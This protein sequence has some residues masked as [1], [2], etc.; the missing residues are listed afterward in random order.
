[1][2]IPKDITK[3]NVLE[4]LKLIDKNGVPR[5]RVYERYFLDFNESKYPVKYVISLANIFAFE[6]QTELPPSNFTTLQAQDFLKKMNFDIVDTLEEEGD[7]HSGF[8]LLRLKLINNKLLGDIDFSF[9]NSKDKQNTIYT[10]VVIGPNGT[11][12]S[13][14]FRIIIE[15]FKELN[16]LKNGQPRKSNVSG[17]FH[18]T[19]ALN[20]GIYA[21]S[22]IIKAEAVAVVS[23]TDTNSYVYF[24]IDGE[25][26][27]YHL[28]D[29]PLALVANSIM[30]TDKYPFY[31]DA[32]SFKNYKYLG[33]R[34]NAQNASTK[35][36]IRR[37]IEYVL[38]E[39]DSSAFR[40]GLKRVAGFLGMSQR[41]EVFYNTIN[42]GV[43]FT[44]R[45]STDIFKNYFDQLVL[46]YNN[47]EYPPQR[48]THY[49]KIVDDENLIKEIVSFCNV[50]KLDKSDNAIINSTV[51][52]ISFDITNESSFQLLRKES[53]ILEHLRQ[54]GIITSPD[55]F[56]TRDDSYS[57]QESSSG[58]YHFFSA[59][60]GLMATVKS[61]SLVFLDEPEIS[62][63]PNWQMKYISFL[64]ELFRDKN[65]S[66]SHI[67][68]ATHSHFLIS[69]LQ[70]DN[71]KIIGLKKGKQADGSMNN[72]IE[73]VDFPKS[74]DTF[75]WSAE[76][77]LY[78][79][80]EVPTTRNKY[81]ADAIGDILDD[82]SKGS[83]NKQNKLK[84][85]HFDL[86]KKLESTLNDIDPLK[87]VVK[88][89]LKQIG[90]GS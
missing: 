10:S 72:R 52:K 3:E 15:L 31:R 20:G 74:L 82:M 53:D 7:K 64:R 39:R 26:A 22:N 32:N 36:Y 12:K 42:A 55:I 23:K 13:N 17:Q 83:K 5:K 58:E 47:S 67:L 35:S 4:A 73:L 65:Y 19:Y 86:L 80:F 14:L 38:S 79:V 45:L 48:A 63:H 62:L 8:K 24:T 89:I 61:N 37:T 50:V 75:G 76:D 84:S 66:T 2:S 1:M 11:G 85:E 25:E 49:R 60:V 43:F 56:L 88:S 29:L 40:D 81:V 90:N 9:I 30:L 44:G 69:D 27:S 68:I 33:V 16:D 51:K 46:R 57:L 70:G 77:V 78:N 41:I 87:T 6:M 59:M 34:N 28:A 71:S 18:L 54:L 21:Y